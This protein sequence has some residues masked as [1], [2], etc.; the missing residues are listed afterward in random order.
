MG[1]PGHYRKTGID[2][3]DMG[4]YRRDYYHKFLSKRARAEA[5]GR[6]HV[7]GRAAYGQ[8]RRDWICEARKQMVKRARLSRG[9]IPVHPEMTSA[10]LRAQFDRQ[11]GRCFYT[12]IRFTLNDKFRGMRNPSIDRIDAAKGYESG[13]V[14]WCLVAINYAKNEYDAG[15]FLQLLADIRTHHP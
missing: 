15:E 7:D 14:V 4:A 9:G 2:T 6:P 3:S 12:G 13:N 10:W 11:R 1:T 5:E 8:L